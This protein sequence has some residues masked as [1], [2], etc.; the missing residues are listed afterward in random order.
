MT[1]SCNRGDMD[2]KPGTTLML[3]NVPG[4]AAERVLLVGLGAANDFR[5]KQYREAM[6]AAMRALNATGAEDAA[7]HLAELPVKQARRGVESR[8]RGD[9]RAGEA[10]TASAA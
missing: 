8:T 7:L 3:H 5:D 1:A 10:P 2:G 6:A 9:G 4:V